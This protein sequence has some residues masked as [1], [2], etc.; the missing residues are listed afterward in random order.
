M[1]L[2]ITNPNGLHVFEMVNFPRTRNCHKYQLKVLKYEP[3]H[4][5]MNKMSCTL[6]E[7]SDQPWHHPSLIRVF[8]VHIMGS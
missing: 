6:R 5:N 2:A 4:D 3:E 7:D 8:P 1:C